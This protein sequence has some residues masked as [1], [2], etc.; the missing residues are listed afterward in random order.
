MLS[1]TISLSVKVGAN[2]SGCATKSTARCASEAVDTR[3]FGH[4]DVG[5]DGGRYVRKVHLA[6]DE[7]ARRRVAERIRHRRAP[8]LRHA[9]VEHDASGSTA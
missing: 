5:L 2:N 6:R 1:N 9:R 7:H 8:G 4:G 3:F